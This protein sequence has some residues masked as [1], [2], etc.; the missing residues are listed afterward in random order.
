M[1]VFSSLMKDDQNFRGILCIK[2]W[3]VQKWSQEQCEFHVLPIHTTLFNPYSVKSIREKNISPWQVWRWNWPPTFLVLCWGAVGGVE[4]GGEGHRGPGVRLA[5][6][7]SLLLVLLGAQLETGQLKQK[8]SSGHHFV[9]LELELPVW[10]QLKKIICSVQMNQRCKT[11]PAI[12]SLSKGKLTD[13]KLSC[14]CQP[15]S[16]SQDSDMSF[17]YKWRWS[18]KGREGTRTGD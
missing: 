4:G 5:L 9:E 11:V 1:R 17:L 3:R 14:L 12:S 8:S 10:H 18:M 16:C 6:Q 2:A 7:L 15:A 13:L